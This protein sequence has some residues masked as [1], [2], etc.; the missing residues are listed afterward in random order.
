MVI[1]VGIE[2]DTAF[3][4][5]G[6]EHRKVFFELSNLPKDIISQDFT[7]VT[8]ELGTLEIVNLRPDFIV[9]SSDAILM[10]EF[11]SSFVGMP[12]KKRFHSYVALFDYFN[13]DDNLDIY[14][15]VLTTKEKTKKATYKIN[16]IDEFNFQVINIK[17]LDFNK[18]I[19][20][21][22]TKIKT[23]EVLT[24]EEAVKLALTSLMPNTRE[25][26][27]KQF[28]TLSDM[29]KSIRFND[30]R[31]RTSFYGLMLLLSNLYFDKD[32][33]FRKNL[34]RGLMNTVDCVMERMEECIR[35]GKKEGKEE[36]S[37]ELAVKLVDKG[38]SMVELAE[39]MEIPIDQLESE[40][41]K[42]KLESK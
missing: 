32:D 39:T 23:K 7:E 18:I 29:S 20:T 15:I 19:N 24:S 10:Y 26:I 5:I 35:E 8:E 40:Y 1:L 9:K 25:E 4:Y 2:K 33:E 17:D 41:Q 16:G 3:K 14:F 21:T 6:K 12:S 30:E 42:Y 38:Y 27:I 37:I 36:G 13:N 31:V 28:E 34:Q 22:K 11:E